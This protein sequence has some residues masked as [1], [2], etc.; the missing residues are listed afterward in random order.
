MISC[1][2]INIDLLQRAKTFIKT[3][4][5]PFANQYAISG[6]LPA[7][8]ITGMINNRFLGTLINTHYQGLN[9]DYSSYGKLTRLF[10][11]GCSSLRSLLTVHDMVCYAIQQFGNENQKNTWLPNLINGNVIAAFALTE[12]TLGSAINHVQTELVEKNTDF[13]LSGTK[14]W[15][16]FG[17]IAKLLLVFA[18][19]KDKYVAVLV[20]TNDPN[21]LIKPINNPLA[22]S[23]SMLAEIQFANVR[24]CPEQI[25]GKNGTGITFVASQC[26]TLGRYSVA[27]GCLGIIDACITATKNKTLQLKP[28][29]SKLIDFQLISSMVTEMLTQRKIVSLLCKNAG[30]KLSQNFFSALEDIMM[31]KYYAAKYAYQIASNTLQ[32]F[33]AEGY[34]EKSPLRR[35]FHDSKAC[36][37]IEG[38]NEIM[39]NIIGKTFI[40]NYDYDREFE[41]I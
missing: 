5:I 41:E 20:P 27:C 16:S 17:Q 11:F 8:L 36:E 39:Q 32:I 37:L 25:I 15:I 26:L 29:G 33:G 35:Y 2:D 4:V 13:Y 30:Y 38:S 34:S 14:T 24:I 7:D 9:L 22:F 21:I 31:A 1:T 19:L 6:I 28:D 40:G 18:K 12:P 3:H 23:A 10:G